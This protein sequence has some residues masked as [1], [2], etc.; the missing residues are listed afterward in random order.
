MDEFISD[1]GQNYNL[2]NFRIKNDMVIF[3]VSSVLKDVVCPYCGHP[4]SKVHSRYQREIQDLPMQ[5]KKVVLLIRTRK[6]F[7]VNSLCNKKTFAE[8][9]PFVATNGKITER[10][11]KN[12]IYT[13]PQLSSI[14]AS[15]TLKS[16]GI[17]ICK[18]SICLLLKKNADNC[19]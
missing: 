2:D 19:G 12:I 6:M 17:D 4:S 16:N 11:E 10:L 1:L 9:H 5:N 8:K 7:C 3:E 13:S 14:G 15:K 18:S